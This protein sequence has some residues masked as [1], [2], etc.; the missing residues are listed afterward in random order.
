MGKSRLSITG[1]MFSL[2]WDSV[3]VATHA[4]QAVA[5]AT[6]TATPPT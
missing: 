6:A 4:Q 2:G 1:K 5:T 3:E